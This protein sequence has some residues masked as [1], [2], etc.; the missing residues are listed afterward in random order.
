MILHVAGR[1]AL[2]GLLSVEF[3][4]KRLQILIL[5]IHENIQAA[6]VRHAD[7]YFLHPAGRGI[8]NDPVHR[9]D[10][11]FTAFERKTLLTRVAL[12]KEV[13]QPFAC[14]EPLKD[15]HLRFRREGRSGTDGL[16]P[17]LPP[18]LLFR[19]RDVH[20]LRADLSAVCLAERFDQ[21]PKRHRGTAEIRVRGREYL[22]EVRV[23]E[24]VV[25]GIEF[26]NHP[27]RLILQRIQ[28]RDFGA[29]IPVRRDKLLHRDLALRE[30][31]H[32]ILRNA[33]RAGFSPRP[34][35]D[36]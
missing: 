32:L 19:I 29:E 14:G 5:N 10:E 33:A 15:M 1:E 9:D 20:E 7:H 28:V 11:G 24:P 3:V 4:V 22:I 23:G 34:G 12:M 21:F 13:F 8:L 30:G 6:A 18:A 26:R 25:R 16:K 36:A 27:G 31:E 35:D 2:G 17:L